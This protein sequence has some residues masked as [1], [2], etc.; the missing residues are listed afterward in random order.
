MIF[1]INNVF[2]AIFF[3]RSITYTHQKIMILF[4][5]RSPT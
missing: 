5:I 3:R 4:Q 1:G 2:M